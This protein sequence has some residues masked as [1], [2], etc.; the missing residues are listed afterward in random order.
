MK[1]CPHCRCE[2]EPPSAGRPR[3]VPQ[4]RRYFAMVRAAHLHWPDSHDFRPHSETHLRK[5]LQCKAGYHKVMTVD[6]A[7]MTPEQAVSMVAAAMREAGD[8]PFTKAVG[9]RLYVF[10]SQSI[11]FDTLP[12]RAACS[13]FDA[14]AEVILAETGLK[15]DQI[16]PQ[17]QAPRA[18]AKRDALREASL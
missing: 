14:V 5:W 1:S 16:M 17:V 8:H 15:P 9:T 6:T 4:H 12:H 10:T 18:P 2:I 13:L 7:G 3:S 11:D